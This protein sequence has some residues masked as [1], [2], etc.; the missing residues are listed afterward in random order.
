MLCW[1]TKNDAK[2]FYSTLGKAWQVL[3]AEL[4]HRSKSHSEYAAQVPSLY[5]LEH[6]SL[7][8]L[9]QLMKE[10]EKPLLDFKESQKK[11]RKEV[12]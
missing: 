5:I 2:Y 11:E 12:C 6:S 10:V 9:P 1:Q 7:Y 8:I 3:K 4:F